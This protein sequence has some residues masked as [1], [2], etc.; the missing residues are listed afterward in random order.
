MNWQFPI[1]LVGPLRGLS[2]ICKRKIPRQKSLE[3]GV[4]SPRYVPNLAYLNW[5]QI[6]IR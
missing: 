6:M 1:Y 5:Q 3:L 4:L 2:L